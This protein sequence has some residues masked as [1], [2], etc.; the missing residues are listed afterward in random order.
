MCIFLGWRYLLHCCKDGFGT[1][2]NRLV[3]AHPDDNALWAPRTC[4]IAYLR[5]PWEE[6]VRHTPGKVW[7]GSEMHVVM[8]RTPS[9]DGPQISP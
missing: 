5:R 3:A 1:L 9:P 8:S 6:E 2:L 7:M 4:D